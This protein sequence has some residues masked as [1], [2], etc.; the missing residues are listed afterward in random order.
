MKLIIGLGNPGSAYEKQLH[1][2]G[3]MMLDQLAQELNAPPFRDK[4]TAAFTKSVCEQEPY[5]LMKPMTYMNRSG[6]AVSQCTQ[7]FKIPTEA[8]V[9]IYDDWDL[10]A[11]TARFR[12]TGGHGGHN[13]VRSIIDALGTQDFK[14]V[15]L[16][17][18]SPPAGMVRQNYVLSNWQAEKWARFQ[19][20]QNH[21]IDGLKKFIGDSTFENVSFKATADSPKE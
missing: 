10:P 20:I 13:G 15:R 18:D 17:I 1:N 3:F 4:F 9:V 16:G 14:R 8:M 19:E 21:V 12:N 6:Q 7:Y 11:G 5:I 2:T